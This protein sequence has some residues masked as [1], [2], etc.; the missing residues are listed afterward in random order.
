MADNKDKIVNGDG[1]N[2]F[3]PS[4]PVPL[5]TLGEVN[6]LG[7]PWQY[8]EDGLTVTRTAPWSPRSINCSNRT[9]RVNPSIPPRAVTGRTPFLMMR[10]R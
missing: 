3:Q 4:H 5:D 7:K 2:L 1:D 8:E 10:C 9:L 6:D